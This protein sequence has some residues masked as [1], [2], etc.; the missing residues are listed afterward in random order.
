MTESE[1]A[2]NNLLHSDHTAIVHKLASCSQYTAL[3]FGFL[4]ELAFTSLLASDL[5]M[6]KVHT[7]RY[8]SFRYLAC[9]A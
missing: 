5:A 9:V 1:D 4:A 6:S 8:P 3:T 2:G 7:L